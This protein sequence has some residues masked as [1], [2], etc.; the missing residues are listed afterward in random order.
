[1]KL[2]ITVIIIT[3]L[4]GCATPI[5]NNTIL[6]LDQVK[7]GTEQTLDSYLKTLTAYGAAK[8]E[9]AETDVATYRKA[10]INKTFQDLKEVLATISDADLPAFHAKVSET[11]TAAVNKK[12]KEIVAPV[13]KKMAELVL[14]VKEKYRGISEATRTIGDYLR[15]ASKYRKSVK[16]VGKTLTSKELLDEIRKIKGAGKYIDAIEEAVRK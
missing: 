4:A 14:A 7:V 1:M 6:L 5:S 2:T 3:L 12:R 16:E 8:E 11:I 13:R 10:L 9:L 15:A